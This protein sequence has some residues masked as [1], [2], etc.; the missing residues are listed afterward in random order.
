[1]ASP[2]GSSV[3]LYSQLH[4]KVGIRRTTDDTTT[5]SEMCQKGPKQGKTPNKL[6]FVDRIC[7]RFDRSPVKI[8]SLWRTVS[9][10]I[11]LRMPCVKTSLWTTV[12]LCMLLG[13]RHGM[14]ECDGAQ[15]SFNQVNHSN[16]CHRKKI[17]FLTY[18]IHLQH[19]HYCSQIFNRHVRW[20]MQVICILALPWHMLL[21]VFF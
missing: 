16:L 12:T 5:L 21:V 19:Y 3:I 2:S 15:T 20:C 11:Q 6:L 18:Y 9:T 1:M 17:P 14:G 10:N 4:L 8:L 13:H 7:Q